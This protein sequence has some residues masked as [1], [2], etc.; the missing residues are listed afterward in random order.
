LP[1]PIAVNEMSMVSNSRV[2]CST[3]ISCQ[4]WK[5]GRSEPGAFST[6]LSSTGLPCSQHATQ[7]AAGTS[8]FPVAQ[9]L[10][11]LECR[12][13]YYLNDLRDFDIA[14]SQQMDRARHYLH[15]ADVD[16]AAAMSVASKKLRDLVLQAEG[17]ALALSS[18]AEYVNLSLLP[19]L[20]AAAVQQNSLMFSSILTEAQHAVGDVRR[21]THSVRSQYV[22]MFNFITYLATCTQLA[23]DANFMAVTADGLEDADSAVARHECTQQCLTRALMHIDAICGLLEECSD[24]WLMM[25]TAEIRFAKVEKDAHQMSQSLVRKSHGGEYIAVAMSDFCGRLGLF[26]KEF[27]EESPEACM[28]NLSMQPQDGIPTRSGFNMSHPPHGLI[29]ENRRGG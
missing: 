10:V 3:T 9:T 6:A 25:H 14:V 5:D 13:K 28:K 15:L 12:T 4:D 29:L 18:T 16:L 21:D 23:S 1:C 8:T 26:C 17:I 27:H 20:M 2:G 24:F 19:Q 22:E 7:S 11:Q